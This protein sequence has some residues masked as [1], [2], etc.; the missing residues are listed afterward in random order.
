MYFHQRQ[1]RFGL[2]IS[3][4]NPRQLTQHHKERKQ[5]T[6]NTMARLWLKKLYLLFLGFLLKNNAV[7]V[8]SPAPM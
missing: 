7:I 2:R 5:K 8:L 6:F 3:A 4:D 1:C